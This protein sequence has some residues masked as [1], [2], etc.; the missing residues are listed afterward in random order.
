MISSLSSS[1][2]VMRTTPFTTL[3][4]RNGRRISTTTTTKAKSLRENIRDESFRGEV[5]GDKEEDIRNTF[6]ESDARRK[7]SNTRRKMMTTTISVA[8]FSSFFLS[9]ANETLA[10]EEE[11]M[12]M[13]TIPDEAKQQQQ[14][15]EGYSK[16][17]A[18][19]FP[20]LCEYK[21]TEKVYFDVSIGGENAGRIVIGLFGEDVPKTVAN[22]RELCANSK[23]FGYQNS[24]FHR[25]IPN[26][27][28]QGG[29]FER[30]N[31]TGG[32]SIYG[33]NFAD[34]NFKIPFT[35]PGVLA[36][37][38]A[39]PNTNGSQFF[40]TTAATP[41]LTGKHVV[42]GN[43]LEGFDVVKKVESTQT[44]RGDR[45]KKDVIVQSGVL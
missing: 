3:R 12:M 28:L 40:L 36:M 23:G 37:A 42:F 2:S 15:C 14:L 4:F 8:A 31:G 32:Y 19:A 17:V 35:G 7:R 29:D 44:G 30:A 33:R 34:E 11:E 39:G 6:I 26:F 10:G 1:S 41:W 45:P 13:K 38:N 9:S 24:I 25:V 18:S 43:V 5:K 16:D 21:V 27:M 22:F 20:N